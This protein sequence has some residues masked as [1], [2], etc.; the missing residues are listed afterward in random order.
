MVVRTDTDGAYIWNGTQWQ[1]LVT[2]T[3]MPAAFVI[4]NSGQG[5]YE[6]QIAPSNTNILYMEYEGYVFKSTNKGTT[7]T[8]TSFAPVTE[9][10]IEG[11]DPYRLWGQKMAVDPNN[12][13]V[14][15]AGT[16]QN[17]LFVTTNGGT[18]WQSVSAVP[19][20]TVNSSGFYR[21]Y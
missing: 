14:V 1:Q 9:P 18:S 16:P 11:N 7:W 15:F 13:N 2:S 17:G 6:I 5:V 10:T 12:P 8:Q 20:G 21:R 4:P 3:S 19:V